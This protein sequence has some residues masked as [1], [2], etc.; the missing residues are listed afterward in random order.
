MD[1][2]LK[3]QVEEYILEIAREAREQEDAKLYEEVE[4]MLRNAYP[5]VAPLTP[6]E[7]RD[8]IR[9]AEE[10]G[11]LEDGEGAA[12][13]K[14]GQGMLG[15]KLALVRKVHQLVVDEF[16]A[17]HGI[18][19]RSQAAMELVVAA[20]ER[21]HKKKKKIQ[22]EKKNQ[23]GK[24]GREQRGGGGGGGDRR[25]GGRRG[26]GR[27]A[28]GTAVEHLLHA[29]GQ[30]DGGG[31][32]GGGCAAGYGSSDGEGSDGPMVRGWG[33]LNDATTAASAATA[34]RQRQRQ[35][36]RRRLLRVRAAAQEVR[37]KKA[38]RGP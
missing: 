37:G 15:R 36:H 10:S 27:G 26:G 9:E 14:L 23:G 11:K 21:Q 18:R 19:T 20:A 29:R 5:L 31:R 17:A 12:A 34:Q 3:D 7:L 28:W 38:R 24:A 16:N 35:R 33:R 22:R 2:I 30:V 13:N 6:D 25:R 32:R 1:T 8:K 4:S